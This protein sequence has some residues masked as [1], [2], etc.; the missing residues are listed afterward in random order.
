ML[1]KGNALLKRGV[2]LMD[3]FVVL[4]SIALAM[5]IICCSIY[6]I[7]SIIGG[8]TCVVKK[9]LKEIFEIDIKND[10]EL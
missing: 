5:I 2:G 6:I 1:I 7:K 8:I 10:E 4:Y 3:S 9:S